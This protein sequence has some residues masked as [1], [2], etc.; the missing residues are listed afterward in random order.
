MKFLSKLLGE[1]TLNELK[2]KLG[3]DLVKSINEKLGDYAIDTGKAKLIPKTVYDE[4][5]ASLKTQIEERDKQLA[6]LKKAAKDNE[7][8]KTKIEE[9]ENLNKTN[10]ANYEKTLT[11]TRQKFAYESAL[12]GVKAKNPK[13]LAG[14]IDAS[15]ITYKDN[16]AGGYT[17][18]GLTEQIDALKKSD[19]YLFEGY[20]Q[21]TPN[22]QNEPQPKPNVE[23]DAKLRAAFGLAPKQ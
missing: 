17:V 15:K 23:A 12:S 7:E 5:K 18:E 13:A 21:G 1:E 11:E 20:T 22:P 6:D 14:L 4:D 2:G 8:F 3:D 9:L 19:A 10:K 16:G